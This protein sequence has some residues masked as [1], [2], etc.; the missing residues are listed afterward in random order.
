MKLLIIKKT[1]ILLLLSLI[2]SCGGGGTDSSVSSGVRKIV[3]VGDSIAAGFGGTN[4]WP[5]LIQE[6]TG[7][8]VVN[9]STPGIQ[10]ARSITGAIQAMDVH[11]PSHIL[12]LLGTNDANNG[13]TE[14]A[15]SA[16]R[17]IIAE[18]TARGIIPVIGTVPPVQS[19]VEITAR[20]SQ[21]SSG[22]RSLGVT[23]AEVEGAF[24]SNGA[25]FLPD[26]F[27]PNNEGQEVIANAFIAVL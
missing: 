10:A 14:A 27:H 9:Q 11:Q 2:A 19:S 24:G 21:I 5:R 4:P 1:I 25:L 3:A 20:T 7:V 26:Q 22:Y 6:K 13:S 23:I 12:V 8:A 17:R 18:A 16:M 15:V